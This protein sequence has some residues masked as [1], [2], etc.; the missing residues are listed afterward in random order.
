MIACPT[1]N[2][3]KTRSG[4]NRE[5]MGEGENPTKKKEENPLKPDL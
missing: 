1:S 3:R 4:E 2:N 5:E